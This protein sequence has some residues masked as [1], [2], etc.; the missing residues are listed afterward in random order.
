V[1]SATIASDWPLGLARATRP[2]PAFAELVVYPA[3]TDLTDARGGTG[4]VA[5]LL[6]AFGSKS[7]MLQPSHLREYR[8][9]D[10]VRLVHWKASARRRSLVIREWEGGNGSG[11]EVVL[12]RRCSDEDLERSLGVLAA[13]VLA[14]R[15]DKVLVRF[16]TQGLSGT[17]GPGRRP[18]AELLRI[19]AIAVAMPEGGPPPPATTPDV[20]RLP[21]ALGPANGGPR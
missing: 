4:D 15:D 21:A 7:G 3:P 12:D 14:A 5:E 1:R 2:I 11:L 9:G 18:W 13:I 10:E 6:G 8:R 16:H 17:F 20:L 19:L